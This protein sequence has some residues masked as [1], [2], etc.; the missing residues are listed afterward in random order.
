MTEKK[1]LAFFS[2]AHMLNPMKTTTKKAEPSAEA[3]YAARR[4]AILGQ[5]E[6]LKSTLDRH[7]T[8]AARE[9]KHYGYAGDLGRIQELLNEAL[10]ALGLQA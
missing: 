3:L 7:A 1:G 5:I 8:K 2:A 10:T 9:P 6:I 4:T